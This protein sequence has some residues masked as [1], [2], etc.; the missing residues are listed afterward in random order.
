MRNKGTGVRNL[1]ENS[2]GYFVYRRPDNGKRF[3]MGKDRH[4]A[5]QAARELNERL[6]TSNSRVEKVLGEKL[7]TITFEQ[8]TQY[9]IKHVWEQRLLLPPGAKGKMSPSTVDNYKGLIKVLN[10]DMGGKVLNDVNF[11][12]KFVA[13][14]L[15][16]QTPNMSQMYRRVFSILFNKAI[17]RGYLKTNPAQMTDLAVVTVARKRLSLELFLAIREEVTPWMQNA[18]DLAIHLGTRVSDISNLRW[19]NNLLIENSNTY[20]QYITGNC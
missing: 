17:S 15:E 7:D 8:H 6:M 5:I 4:Q 1:Y 12:V 13:S 9:V 18:M 3:G 16:R 20:L 2:N 10:R 19:K 11:T 14:F